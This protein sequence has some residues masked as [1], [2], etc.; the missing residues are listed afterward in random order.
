M[1]W[2][3]GIT[4][5]MEMSLG[6]LLEFDGQGSLACYS[7]WGCKELNTTERLN[8]FTSSGYLRCTP[9]GTSRSASYKFLVQKVISEKLR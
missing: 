7:L 9:V 5:L 3:D 1:R 6:N 2:L 4:N 8:W